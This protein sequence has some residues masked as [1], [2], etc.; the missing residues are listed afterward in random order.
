MAGL[1]GLVSATTFA[2]KNELTKARDEYAKFENLRGTTPQLANASLK[3]ARESI[4]K[5][6]ANE[7][8]AT[9]PQT[10]AVK[11]A[12]YAAYAIADSVATT[13]LP[14]YTT[15]DEAYKKAK[16][17]DTKGENKDVIEIASKTLAQYQLN[18]GVNEYQSG[19]YDLAYASFNSFREIL[20]ED[21]NAIY[22][23]GLSAANA[24]PKDPKFLPLA[25]TNYNKLLTTAYSKNSDIYFEL[26]TLYLTAK[27]T[28]AALKAVSD[29][30]AKYPTN[31]QL[32]SREIEISLVT[33]KQEDAIAKIQSAIANDPK[34]KS[35]YYYAGITYAKIGDVAEKQAK[36]KDPVKKAE[37]LKKKTENY[38]LASS[39]YIKALEVDPNY[40]D[41][42][43]NLGYVKINPAIDAY[44]AA[45]AV[46]ANKQKEYE[47]ASA[48]AAALFTEAKP[49]MLKAVELNPKSIEALTNLKSYYLGT[50]DAANAT[51]TQKQI[52]ALSSK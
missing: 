43:L 15:A 44:N 32:R 1:L 21:T 13:S 34:N 4:D 39:M 3:N 7:K 30:V 40:A 47:A 23:T 33:G 6:A 26:S 48:K 18:K 5:A 8:T 45:N 2:Q 51:K 41:A 49:Y 46:P 9:L 36:T 17:T 10:Y 24:S 25:I 20:P 38:A 50:K 31:T 42:A 11:A 52:E 35:L 14:L 27:D 28:T 29:G 12:V 16:E 37:A 22:Y 19:K